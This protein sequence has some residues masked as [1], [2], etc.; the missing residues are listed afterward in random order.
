MSEELTS[1][2]NADAVR[3]GVSWLSGAGRD[4]DVVVSSR[5]RLARNLAGFPFLTR[6]TRQHRQA[7]LDR[8]RARVSTLR[9]PE[10]SPGR[11]LWVDVHQTTQADRL[12][13]VERHLI[14]KEHAKGDEPRGVA[15]S[16][17]DER[18]SLM[19]NEE[20]QLRLQAL[21]PGLQIA[22]AFAQI[23]SI[24]DSLAGGEPGASPADAPLEYAF[25][26]RFGYLTA[27]PTNVGTGMR[28][29]VMLHLPALRLTGEMEKV[30]RATKDMNLA[31]RGYYGEGSEATGELYQISNQ[32]TLGKPEQTIMHELEHEILPQVIGYERKA[33]VLM[34]EKRRRL[35]ED[36]VFRALGVLRHARL[37][38][39]EEALTMLSNVRL[40][41][42]TGLITDVP[43]E[44]VN[45]LFLLTQPAHLQRALGVE[46]DQ[47]TRREA[48]ADLVRERLRSC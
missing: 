20:D 9:Q 4:A 11:L 1:V 28:V 30:R 44:T 48:R 42:L 6:A 19:V 14:S 13:M 32:T 27:C 3:A 24:D 29:S 25:S 26:P 15:I 43:I 35:L 18:V 33:R 46:M 21:R 7:V 41:F 34:V 31:V 23:N 37:L 22:E 16:L 38:T 17:P 8:V 45:Q 47:A 36:T 5:I 12:L 10:G 40:G 2:L 39:P